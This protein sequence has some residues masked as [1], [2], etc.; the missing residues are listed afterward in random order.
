MA[1]GQCSRQGTGLGVQEA[2]GSS[3]SITLEHRVQHQGS[4]VDGG[5]VLGCLSSLSVSVSVLVW[6][7]GPESPAGQWFLLSQTQ[8]RSALRTL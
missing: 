7:S 6:A 5:V 3:P 4:P 2:L 8:A 1:G